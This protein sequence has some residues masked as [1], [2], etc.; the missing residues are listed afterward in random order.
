MVRTDLKQHLKR[1]RGEEGEE[2]RKENGRSYFF[3]LNRL[4]RFSLSFSRFPGLDSIV[5][6]TAVI[7]LTEAGSVCARAADAGVLWLLVVTSNLSP[8][9][10]AEMVEIHV[11]ISSWKRRQSH[12]C[13]VTLRF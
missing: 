3:L 7:V 12:I 8:D 1:K 10:A 11:F 2:K 5:V 4:K 9:N 13:S 6:A